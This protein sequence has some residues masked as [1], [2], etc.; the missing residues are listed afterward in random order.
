M[1]GSAIGSGSGSV[2]DCC[3]VAFT[4]VLDLARLLGGLPPFLRF[5]MGST[6][7]DFRFAVDLFRL[8]FAIALVT[9]EL[10][11][12]IRTSSRMIVLW[13]SASIGSF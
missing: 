12:A 11:G 13:L 9:L 8:V 5:G 2:I 7:G 10:A 4:V 3:N 1:G 6:G